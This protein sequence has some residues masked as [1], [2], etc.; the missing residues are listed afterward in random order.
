MPILM[1]KLEHILLTCLRRSLHHSMSSLNLKPGHVLL[2][3]LVSFLIIHKL[4]SQYSTHKHTLPVISVSILGV[5]RDSSTY[6]S[7]MKWKTDQSKTQV[8]F[9]WIFGLPMRVI[10]TGRLLKF[11]FSPSRTDFTVVLTE[12]YQVIILWYD[13]RHTEILETSP[14]YMNVH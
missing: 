10:H 5:Y 2:T 8:L 7:T 14:S 4:N 3:Y 1:L 9:Y 13:K 11:Y 6:F 12:P